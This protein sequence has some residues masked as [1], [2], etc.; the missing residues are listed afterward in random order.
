MVALTVVVALLGQQL[1][2]SARVTPE[3][4]LLG[5]SVVLSITVQ[6]RGD[7]SVEIFMP[8]LVGFE[9]ENTRE[10]SQVTLDAGEAAR[11]TRRVLTLRPVRVGTISIPAV[12]VRQGSEVAATAPLSV[13][14]ASAGAAS[15]RVLVPSVRE[16]VV[17]APA[18]RLQTDEVG[19]SVLLSADSVLLGE[20]IDLVVIAWFP[21]GIRS[22]LRNPPTL[23]P[24]PLQGAWSYERP[25][26]VGIAMSRQVG[27]TWYDLFVHHQAVFPLAVGMVRVGS[28]TVSYSLPLTYSFLSRELRHE[29]ET[30]PLDVFVR[31]HHE[32][33]DKDFEGAAGTGLTLSVEGGTTTV[34]LGGAIP[35]TA[36][37][38]GTG[39]VALWPEPRFEW[40]TGLRVYPGDVT[41]SISAEAGKLGGTKVFQYLAVADSIGAFRIP[42]AHYAYFDT[43][44]ERHISLRGPALAVSV[45]GQAAGAGVLRA[46]PPRLVQGTGIVGRTLHA[47]PGWL[48]ILAYLIVPAALL[49]TRILPPL[50][51][52]WQAKRRRLPETPTSPLARLDKELAA[53]LTRL[54]GPR[55][56]GD[57]LADALRAAGIEEP[58][59]AHAARVRDRLHRALYGPDT[60]ADPSELS[61]EVE[62]VL[63]VLLGTAS[64]SRQ[65]GVLV[66][67]VLIVLAVLAGTSAAGQSAER[68]YETGAVRAAADS[69]A[70]R[71]VREPQRA[72]H[73]FNLGSA[74]YRLGDFAG[75]RAAWVRAQRL[76]PRAAMA[77]RSNDLVPAADLMS[78]RLTW[79]SP[80]TPPEALLVSVMLWLAGW[81]VVGRRWR[82]RIA[83]LLLALSVASG[84]YAAYVATQYS[85]PVALVR[86]DAVPLRAAP[87]GSAPAQRS[88]VQGAAVV[89]ADPHGAWVR[90]R[91]GREV[92]W[93]LP[94]ELIPL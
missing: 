14:V 26:P 42:P 49:A 16:L 19:A 81:V 62:E 33:G 55:H 84:A 88:L 76:A 93:L 25:S 70:A 65:S 43:D 8:Q 23:R 52:R 40:P 90:V 1:S 63:R 89:M 73:W 11:I 75:A 58:L 53:V 83:V 38:R 7:Q 20:Q 21:R 4:V 74:R 39:N 36:T 24:P 66:G 87:Y 9:V 15:D 22:R 31:P 37:V 48:W 6:S 91:R 71:A 54:V 29:V 60:T 86:T 51:Q 13:T 67:S 17:R 28:A 77:S 68:L 85:R 72:E 18:P 27:G 2:V 3:Q 47:I 32:G 41:V 34:P 30:A 69:F 64:Q 45:S 56:D 78:R 79:V 12:R 61:A 35:I 59:A 94:R 44:R 82:T 50:K 5:D 92:G 10:Q 80:I 57:R 46:T